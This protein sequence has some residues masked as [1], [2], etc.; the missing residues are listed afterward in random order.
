[1][2]SLALLVAVMVLTVVVGAL[3]GLALTYVKR[4]WAQIVAIIA[5]LPASVFATSIFFNVGSTGGRVIG[6]GGLALCALTVVR[7]AKNLKEYM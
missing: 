4:R 1:M 2:E 5:V 3:G 6:G 7:A